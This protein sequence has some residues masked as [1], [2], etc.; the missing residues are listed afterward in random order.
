MFSLKLQKKNWAKTR[1]VDDFLVIGRGVY[2][3]VCYWFL[4]ECHQNSS[5][6][7]WPHNWLW[8][9]LLEAHNFLKI[10]L[11]P[12]P[13][14]NK[15]LLTCLNIQTPKAW[16]FFL[17]VEMMAFF[18]CNLRWWGIISRAFIIPIVVFKVLWQ[19]ILE[20]D[21]V[22]HGTIYFRI[23]PNLKQMGEFINHTPAEQNMVKELEE[24][25]RWKIS[26]FSRFNEWLCSVREAKKKDKNTEKRVWIC[27]YK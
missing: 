11:F 10:C 15:L 19:P 23:L 8:S 5:L 1:M 12:L 14:C 20:E 17:E 21:L 4:Q 13:L 6:R 27:T 26:S 9:C 24:N 18:E 2:E 16:K 22:I 3:N 25:I 7:S